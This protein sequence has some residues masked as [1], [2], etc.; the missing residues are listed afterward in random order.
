M[1]Q[2]F[3]AEIRMV[4]WNFPARSWAL[5]NGQ[6]LPI[7][8]NQALFSLLGTTYGGNGQT[9]F[10]LPNLQGRMPMHYGQGA[11]LSAR[12]LGNYGGVEFVTQQ[13]TQIP[14]SPQS[15]VQAAVGF[16][17]QLQ[18]MSP[19]IVI[20]FIIALQGIFPSRN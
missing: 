15:P 12:A 19:F 6:I 13:T 3:L 18:T 4:G 10:A 17:Q 9:T 11:G 1:S 16:Q 7:N 8:Q 20:N 2:P 14:G 5:T